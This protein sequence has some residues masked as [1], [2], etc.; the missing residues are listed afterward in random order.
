MAK[1]KVPSIN[2]SSSADIAFMLLIFFLV[3]SSMGSDKGLARQLPPAVPPDQD[4]TMD[5]KKRN[6]LR[7]LVNTA[8]DII[9]NGEEVTL[10]QLKNKVKEF[11]LNEQDDPNMPEME[12]MEIPLIGNVKVSKYHLISL[13]SVVDTRYND[14]IAVQNE[15]AKAYRELRDEYGMTKWGKKMSELSQEQQEALIKLYPQK[16]SEANPKEYGKKK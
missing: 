3:T 15:I 12:E 9:C 8:G 1:R 2:G 7:V 16:I 5:L 13:T 6:M 10:V 4:A 11:V 14:Y